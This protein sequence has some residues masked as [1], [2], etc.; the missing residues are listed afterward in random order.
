MSRSCN[1]SRSVDGGALIAARS[2]CTRTTRSLIGCRATSSKNCS[3]KMVRRR[4]WSCTRW[5]Q[6]TNRPCSLAPHSRSG[7]GRVVMTARSPSRSCVSG[8]R[9]RAAPATRLWRI[10]LML[11]SW[12]TVRRCR[13]PS[14]A[15]PMPR[16]KFCRS[17]SS[18]TS[19]GATGTRP[20]RRSACR[21]QRSEIVLALRSSRRRAPCRRTSVRGAGQPSCRNRSAVSS[22]ILCTTS[23]RRW[24]SRGRRLRWSRCPCMRRA[25]SSRLSHCSSPWAWGTSRS[26]GSAMI[27]RLS[28]GRSTN[29]A[30]TMAAS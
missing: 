17:P 19:S 5:L 11:F 3:Q 1:A 14:D 7:F 23:F 8:R 10:T 4:L 18:R 15:T 2:R 25:A 29:F 30:I 13:R 26:Q 27:S 16:A 20:S 12:N 9:P 28:S 22:Q 21:M 6:R 24:S